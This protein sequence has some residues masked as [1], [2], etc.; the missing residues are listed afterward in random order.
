MRGAVFL[1]RATPAQPTVA[2][3]FVVLDPES[4]SEG[5]YFSGLGG[6]GVGTERQIRGNPRSIGGETGIMELDG[7]DGQIRS[8]RVSWERLL[9][10]VLGVL[11]RV[12]CGALGSSILS[13]SWPILA[14]PWRILAPS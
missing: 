9:K 13:P 14:P 11:G 8:F 4:G 3:G 2:L 7:G 1:P 12:A 10:R 6:V 5:F